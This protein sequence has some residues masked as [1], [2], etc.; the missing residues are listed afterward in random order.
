M[1]SN[2]LLFITKNAPVL[3]AMTAFTF[4]ISKVKITHQFSTTTR[5]SWRETFLIQRVCKAYRVCQLTSTSLIGK[6]GH[7]CASNRDSVL[8]STLLIWVTHF[9]LH[10]VCTSRSWLMPPSLTLTGLHC[11]DMC[12]FD[13]KTK[14][15]K[16]SLCHP[17]ACSCIRRGKQLG[18]CCRQMLN[19]FTAAIHLCLTFLQL[20]IAYSTHIL[21]MN[22]C[23]L[24]LYD[25]KVTF[26]VQYNN[27]SLECSK[28]QVVLKCLITMT[29]KYI[30]GHLSLCH[31]CKRTKD[32]K[33]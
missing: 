3:N 29:K 16:N 33:P 25:N 27:L 30:Y 1:A 10:W 24:S 19:A 26:V 7:F 14:S 23:S 5:S 13:D 31:Q 32:L 15:K 22:H 4:Y 6:K 2:Y 12:S 11:D 17:C 18:K 28:K 20:N 21:D 9:E 8:S